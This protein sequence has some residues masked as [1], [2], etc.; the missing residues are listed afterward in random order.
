MKKT[1]ASVLFATLFTSLY[2]QNKWNV[3]KPS[4]S[5]KTVSI[6]TNEGT[7]MN[8]DVSPDGKELVFD[9]LGDI[10][11]MPVSG[12]KAT[13]LAGGMACEVQPRFSPD[14][15]HI[16]YTSDK[17][18]AN[19]IWVMN[20][21]GSD[22]H[23]VTSE[24]Y[25]LQQNAVWATDNQYLVACK[26]FTNMQPLGAGEIWMYH[27][28]GDGAGIQLIK[29]K[30]D[31]QGAGEPAVS[32]KGKYI[33]FS[34]N[35][36]TNST[37]NKDPNGE[38]YVI[39]RLNRETGEIITVAGG[40]GGASRPQPSPDGK[41][42][43][44]VKR[45]RLKSV[46]YLQNLKTGEEWSVYDDL[47]HDLQESAATFGVYPNFGWTPDA[48]YIIFYAKGK[49]RK[50]DI[51]TLESTVIPFE[52]N[53][54]QTLAESLHFDQKAFQDEFEVKMI[55]QLTTSP[56]G[57]KVA[58]NAAGHIYIKDLPNGKPQRITTSADLEY[59]P[60]FS[61]DGASLV[62]VSWNDETKGSI[63]RIDLKT[64]TSSILTSDRG[65]YYSPS[66][67][68][69]GDKIVYRKGTGNITLGFAFGKNPGIYLIPATGGTPVKL[70]E[71]GQYPVFSSN[72]SRIFFQTT[73]GKKKV[74][75]SMDL[76][77]GSIRTHYSSEYATRFVP[78]PDQ[79]W[80]AFNELFNVY[81]T[82]MVTIGK[83]QELSSS[84]KSLPLSR[85][86]RD[87][88]SC[89]HWSK[90]SK[91]LMWV[92][93]SQ[94]FS[95]EIKNSFAFAE[96]APDKLPPQ[97]TDG[98]DIGL[99]LPAD[100][101]EGKIAFTNARI[102]T[103]KGDEV[104]QDGSIVIERNRI[105]AVGP[106]KQVTIPEDAKVVDVRGKTIMPGIVDV[107]ANLQANTG[108][109]S[110]QQDWNYLANLAFGVTTSQDFSG[111]AEMSISQAEMIRAGIVRGPRVYAAG[112]ILDEPDADP[113]AGINSLDDARSQLRRLKAL[114][115]FSVTSAS[116]P[117]R[118]QRQQLIQAAREF[119]MNVMP[120]GGSSFFADMS[121]ILD[122][123]TGIERNT[124][125]VPV[126]KDVQSLWNESKVGYTP[127]LIVSKGAQHGENFWY[128]RT[129]V[130]ENDHLL[131]FTPRQ[132]I[133]AR[134]RR[135]TTSEYGDYGHIDVSRAVKQIAGGGT[136]VNLGSHGQL[137]G[138]GAHW[139]LWMLVQGGMSPLQAIRCATLNGAQYL[140]MG[141]EL[142]SLEPGK[143]ADL[144]VLK[145]NPL[146][147]IRNS[148]KIE[149]VMANGRLYDA[150]TMNETGNTEKARGRF[151]WEIPHGSTINNLLPDTELV[152][153]E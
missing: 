85:V 65:F 56:D 146:S 128:D 82:P 67:S 1:L 25:S 107:H 132:V 74:F 84:N 110:P 149:Y 41:Y 32:P 39:K 137:Q 42:L 89:L 28:S 43:A 10:Y 72:D 87:A 18:G 50:L 52:V 125:V 33:Y 105:I 38:L 76:N 131:N 147:D 91:K 81:I 109:I 48:Q 118:D 5:L 9:L 127:M 34:E 143:L 126:Y 7:W 22:K 2:A 59:D 54:Q 3:E 130:W 55:R 141:K 23:A 97:E 4:G 153:P 99:K 139:E 113:Q 114:G 117:R 93:G 51:T 66:F 8:L 80:I 111:N 46:L 119:K 106:S 78:S 150:E 49:I 61:P 79:K 16:S 40:Q 94:Y 71:D 133:D 92:L 20:A 140:G 152:I 124:P 77:G 145:A 63:N 15:K 13:I 45:V 17:D 104:I 27:I 21:D 60:A 19:N 62:Y 95:R 100:N 148:E 120:E 103:M 64:G 58:F 31:Q 69:K 36:S 29:R 142:G 96:G 26:N 86:S 123:N 70:T 73:E 35:T 14:G 122:G 68:N 83:P 30:N 98:I 12:G 134:S 90:D 24:N 136:K 138:L 129:N 115:I 47:S 121:M 101:P 116:Q 44:F 144:V 57:K 6:T 88:G 102:I 108:G 112:T 11:K 151:W 75:K 53:S 37:Y 135:R